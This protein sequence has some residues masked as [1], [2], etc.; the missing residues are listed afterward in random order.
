M[1]AQI[2]QAQEAEADW[3]Q[4][5][6]VLT[7]LLLSHADQGLLQFSYYYSASGCM[8]QAK[9]TLSRTTKHHGEVAA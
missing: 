9:D 5:V 3:K 4:Q 2:R 1:L 8:P 6:I 7:M